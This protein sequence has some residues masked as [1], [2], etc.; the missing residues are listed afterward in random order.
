MTFRIDSSRFQ[1]NRMKTELGR[2]VL[3]KHQFLEKKWFANS[4]NLTSGLP[5]IN[6]LYLR[7][8]YCLLLMRRSLWWY[9]ARSCSR[10]RWGICG[11]NWLTR[12]VS[13][14]GVRSAFRSRFTLEVYQH[15]SESIT[16]AAWLAWFLRLLPSEVSTG[17]LCEF[18][19]VLNVL[20]EIL[21]YL[22]TVAN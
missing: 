8:S 7:C 15:R 1:G 10:S 13:A 6:P 3:V 20:R 4:C 9:L 11:L 17:A 14:P 18:L 5:L 19:Y 22:N 16:D 2:G 21:T 12:S